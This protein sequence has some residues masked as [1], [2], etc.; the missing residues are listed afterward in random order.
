M[1]K[2]TKGGLRT[3]PLAAAALDALFSRTQ[4]RVLGLLFG[5]PRRSFYASELIALAAVGSG[6]VQREL[7]RLTDSGLIISNQVGHQKHFRANPS[8]PLFGELCGIALKTDGLARTLRDRLLARGT[9]I[10]AAWILGNPTLDSALRDDEVGLLVVCTEPDDDLI[11]ELE[12]AAQPLG[13]ALNITLWSPQKFSKRLK[14]DK[15]FV[16]RHW[17]QARTWIAGSDTGLN[18]LAAELL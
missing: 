17:S 3:A 2:L 16:R 12:A 15:K 10:R 8:S 4:Q 14:N 18:T 1:G 5:Q 11:T 13:F 6:T 7:A 9:Q